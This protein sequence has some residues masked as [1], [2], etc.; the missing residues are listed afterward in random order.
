M[1]PSLKAQNCVEHEETDTLTPR[2]TSLSLPGPGL[3]TQKLKWRVSMVQL[4][5]SESTFV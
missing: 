2:E 1:L 4:T 5:L 3:C